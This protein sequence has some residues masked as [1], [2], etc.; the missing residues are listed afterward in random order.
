MAVLMLAVSGGLYAHAGA[1][2]HDHDH[3]HESHV[4]AHAADAAPA[5]THDHAHI[6][7]PGDETGSNGAMLHCGADI[8]FP[9]LHAP[10]FAARA[11]LTLRAGEPDA[12]VNALL[13]RDPPPPRP[14]S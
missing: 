7:V 14:V 10:A 5:H 12:I 9:A 1:A 3:G 11:R 6:G 8:H 13:P 2:P 4:I